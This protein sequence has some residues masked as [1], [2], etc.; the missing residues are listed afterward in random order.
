MGS[1]LLPNAFSLRGRWLSRAKPDEVFA[2]PL[3]ADSPCQ[4][5]TPPVRGRCRNA[6]ERVGLMSRRDKRGRVGGP[7]AVEG[8]FRCACHTFFRRKKYAKTPP[9]CIGSALAEPRA[10]HL[11]RLFLRHNL[12]RCVPYRIDP[13]SQSLPFFLYQQSHVRWTQPHL[14]VLT[15][16]A[17]LSKAPLCK[18][19]CQRS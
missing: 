4:G 6:T 9:T 15:R 14:C 7:L 12:V 17:L 19:S 8:L 10:R 5:P 18:G 16:S 2:F 3:R 11:R 1:A 13:A